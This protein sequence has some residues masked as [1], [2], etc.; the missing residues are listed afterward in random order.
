MSNSKKKH[1]TETAIMLK[2]QQAKGAMRRGK[3]LLSPIQLEFDIMVHGVRLRG[4][5]KKLVS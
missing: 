4:Y 5:T 3:N 1:K 2:F